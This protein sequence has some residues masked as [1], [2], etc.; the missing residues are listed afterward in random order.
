[1]LGAVLAS[2]SGCAVWMAARQPGKKDLGVL[3]HGV[4]RSRVLAE[5]GPPVATTQRD[6]KTVDVF[7]FKQGYGKLAKTGRVLLHGT[8]DVLTLGLW[9]LVGT[10][11]EMYFDG[12]DVKVEITY[13]DL[14]QVERVVVLEGEEVIRPGPRFAWGGAAR[15]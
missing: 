14:E 13:D 15:S 7:A 8:A 11:G 1:M 9:E 10:P 4:S 6:G 3:G 2:S 5:I 12:H